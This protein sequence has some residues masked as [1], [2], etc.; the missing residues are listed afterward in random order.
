MTTLKNEN[1]SFL[2]DENDENDNE[3]NNNQENDNNENEEFIISNILNEEDEKE[4]E[5]DLT[6]FVINY[7]I[8]Y[9]VKQLLQ[10]C[11]YYGIAKELRTNK[12][13]K[14]EIINILV[15]FENDYNNSEIVFKRQTMWLYINELKND[16]HMKKYIIF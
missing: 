15:H 16:S 7:Q 3:E 14:D 2:I 8:N 9:T 4:D 1:I 5:L 11:D 13:N 6:H 10:I 12:C